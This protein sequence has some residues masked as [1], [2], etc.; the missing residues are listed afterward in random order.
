MSNGYRY[1]DYNGNELSISYLEIKT[2]NKNTI[3]GNMYTNDAYKNSYGEIK[4]NLKI[5]EL[6]NC[7][8]NNFK[9]NSDNHIFLRKCNTLIKCK[10]RENRF[11]CSM[12]GYSI[13]LFAF[14]IGC[15]CYFTGW[16][17]VIGGI[18]MT[19]E[20]FEV[21]KLCEFYDR[22]DNKNS[23]LIY[24]YFNI[25]NS[26]KMHKCELET[27]YKF[28]GRKECLHKLK[29]KYYIGSLHNIYYD[30]GASNDLNRC[31][32]VSEANTLA[33]VG[34]C[35]LIFGVLLF[36]IFNFI[37]HQDFAKIIDKK[38][39]LLRTNFNIFKNKLLELPQ[40]NNL[41]YLNN[42]KNTD[43]KNIELIEIV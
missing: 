14:V 43:L 20:I 29:D 36:L 17:N 30:R 6:D 3:S 34:L 35:V 31:V 38:N 27:G 12:C 11:I 32:T 42:L 22:N 2:I 28:A 19:K 40:Q 21:T 15:A 13:L 1:I 26:H 5:I 18:R 41:N 16:S 23:H 39:E 4:N 25:S 24:G 33:I 37:F 10:Q 7:D 8:I 9:I